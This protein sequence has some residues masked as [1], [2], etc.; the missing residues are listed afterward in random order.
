MS[1]V[2][3]VPLAKDI[4]PGAG[5]PLVGKPLFSMVIW[6]YV[7]FLFPI[8]PVMQRKVYLGGKMTRCAY[9]KGRDVGMCGLVLVASLPFV[10]EHL[11]NTDGCDAMRVGQ[12]RRE[13]QLAGD[14]DSG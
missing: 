7:R 3:G 10:R 9:D 4:W 8:L 1:P 5:P 6:A 13:R 11:E 2:G 14:G 12:T